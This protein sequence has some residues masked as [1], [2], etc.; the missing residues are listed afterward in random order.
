ML[1]YRHGVAGK[2][3]CDTGSVWQQL[4][5]RDS[6]FDQNFQFELWRASDCHCALNSGVPKIE[7]VTGLTVFRVPKIIEY[8]VCE[9]F[10][11]VGGGRPL[12]G[13]LPLV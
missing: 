9:C 1:P 2:T 13:W 8:L 7:S 11:G 10:V 12:S 4:W 6:N 5:H 3:T